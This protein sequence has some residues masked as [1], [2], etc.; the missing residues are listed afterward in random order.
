MPRDRIRGGDGNDRLFGGA[1]DDRLFGDG[2]RDRLD[3]GAQDDVLSGGPGADTF[4]FRA[5]ADTITDFRDDV[6]TIRLGDGF[7]LAS[8]SQALAMGEEVGRDVVFD[9]AGGETLTVRGTSLA[10]LADDLVV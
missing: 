9:F 1:G 5:G 4:V 7:G 10:A 2:G 6:D 8:V 3:G